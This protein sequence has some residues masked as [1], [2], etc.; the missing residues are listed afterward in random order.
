MRLNLNWGFIKWLFRDVYKDASFWGMLAL[1][2]A[3]LAWLGDVDQTWILVL[4]GLGGTVV[5]LDL[6]HSFIRF[7]HHLYRMEQR[8]ILRELERKN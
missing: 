1:N 5:L 3:V 4:A 6:L 2:L 7:Q 8:Q